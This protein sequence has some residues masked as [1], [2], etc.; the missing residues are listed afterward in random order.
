MRWRM[1]AG[2]REVLSAQASF[3]VT[4]K[5]GGRFH[6]AGHVRARVGQTCVV[7][8]DPIESD[9]DEPI[10]LIFAPPEQIPQMAALVDEAERQRRVR[11]RIRRS[12]S[13][14]ASS[15]SAGSPPT[16][17]ISP[18]IPIRANPTP[19]SS[20]WLKPPDPEDHPFA[21]LK[22]LKVEAEK[23]RRKEAQ[24]QVS[25][26]FKWIDEARIPVEAVRVS[27]PGILHK[28]LNYIDI[29]H[30]AQ[31]RPDAAPFAKRPWSRGCVGTGTRYCRGPAGARRCVSPSAAFGG[32]FPVRGRALRGPQEIRFPGRSCR[33]RFES[34]LTPWVAMSAHRSSFPAPRFL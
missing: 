17:C 23:A 34:R 14:T 20:P 28:I 3:D 12:R 30:I 18:S 22:A 5:S 33:K 24:G 10:D 21:A 11:H 7:T 16:R 1:S 25:R 8:L 13:R 31:F 6:V 27:R 32:A 2:L 29:L 19:C 4:P 26:Q 15:I 9:I